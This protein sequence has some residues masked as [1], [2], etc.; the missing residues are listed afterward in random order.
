[1]LRV[2]RH[3]IPITLLAAFLADVTVITL[4]V[5]MAEKFGSWTGEGE[6]WPKAAMLAVLTVFSFSIADLYKGYRL[7]R[8]ELTARLLLSLTAAATVMGAIGFALP[9]FR[10]GRLAFAEVF[11]VMTVGLLGWRLSWVALR[12]AD[13]LRQ[14]VLVVGVGPAV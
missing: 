10:F 14:R 13:R 8:R 5:A 3:H 2:F 12:P 4:A 6:L 11:A 1:M 9:W 7:A